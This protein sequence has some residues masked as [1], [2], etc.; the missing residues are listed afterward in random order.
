[1]A[2]SPIV[3]RLRALRGDD[4]GG[5]F[6]VMIY[7]VLAVAILGGIS[8]IAVVSGTVALSQRI[9]QSAQAAVRYAVDSVIAEVNQ[10][11]VKSPTMIIDSIV[12]EEFILTPDGPTSGVVTIEAA[13]FDGRQIN[14]DLSVV[15]LGRVAWERGGTATLQLAQATSLSRIEDGRAVWDFAGSVGANSAPGE[16]VALWTPGEVLVYVPGSDPEAPTAPNPPVIV[17]DFDG[18]DVVFTIGSNGGCLPGE[19]YELVQRFQVN[20]GTWSS[21]S[22]TTTVRGALNS[23][24]TATLEARTRCVSSDRTSNWATAS[25]TIVRSTFIPSP[26]DVDILISETG[27]ATITATASGEFPAGAT[28]G[29]Q[30]RVLVGST[31]SDWSTGDSITV[32]VTEGQTLTAQGRVRALD[33]DGDSGWVES[34]EVQATR[35]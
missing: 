29:T 31:W 23:G 35:P 19:N 11:G 7:A 21:W 34:D 25:D 20:G 17:S 32:S 4:R 28:V 13:S 8:S 30:V 3:D 12:G 15:S 9:S 24:G 14:L 33:G 2:R 16:V 22:P 5:A 1:M 27:Q 18:S 6:L 26:P 10:G